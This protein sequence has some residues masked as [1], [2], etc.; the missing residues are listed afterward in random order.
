[1]LVACTA[2]LRRRLSMKVAIELGPEE[3]RVERFGPRGNARW[4]FQSAWAKIRLVRSGQRWYPGRLM[5]GAH[6]REVEVGEFLTDKEREKAARTL[7][8]VLRKHSAW[9]GAC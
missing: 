5:I 2:V 7:K 9:E 4:S 8:Q 1:M 3:V 6:G